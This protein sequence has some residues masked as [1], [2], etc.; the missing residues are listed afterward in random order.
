MTAAR[1]TVAAV[2]IGA[3]SG[4]VCT[5]DFDG[6]SLTL[7]V[8]HRFEHSPLTR[9]GG[10]HWDLD[11]IDTEVTAGLA[12]LSRSD[13]SIASVGVDTWGVDYGL[14]D[15]DG[16][17]V[18]LP[19]CHRDPSRVAAMHRAIESVGAESM[20]DSTGIQITPI[21]TVF[22]LLSDLH[23]HPDRIANAATMLMLP[24]VFHH[25]LSGSTVTEF[26]A[27]S[28]SGAYDMSGRR[29]AVD[30]L[31]RLGIP[32]RLL[33]EVV[34][35]GT[36]VGP[37]RDGTGALAG[38]RVILPP[39]HD[40]AS[41]VVAVPF[42]EPHALFISSGTWSLVGVEVDHA[43]TTAAAR[44]ANLSN[45]GGYDSTIRLLRNVMGLWLLQ[46]CRKQWAIEG[47]E[48]TYQ[49]IADAAEAEP[50][51]TSLI[52]PDSTV[53]L[54][55]GDM[56]ARIRAYC[57][58]TGGPVPHSIGEIARC[59]ADSLALSYAA[60]ADDIADVT[61]V[62]PPAV[63]VVGGGAS[64]RL[65]AQLTADAVGVPVLTGPVEATALGNAAAQLV[66]LG[67]LAGLPQIRDVVRATTDVERYEPRPRQ[68]WA[69]AHARFKN[70][71]RLATTR[72]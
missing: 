59:V 70:L 16:G 9:N 30:L 20:Y 7:E 42:T 4:R 52:D 5:V 53:F 1:R 51:L 34:A 49:E 63:H 39:G 68:E 64:H 14:L 67:E 8:G 44:Q 15:R 22:G 28:T 10:L 56:P 31:D 35:P 71:P 6:R 24:D 66:A 57:A 26:T 69:D 43:I 72:S 40:T 13:R 50:G 37:L 41:A 55:P 18:D 58:E 2:D 25:R 3:E 29:W 27:A 46:E 45:E 12:R 47:T 62:R 23:E 11:R 61:G 33:P 32:V 21:N 65:L 38:T 48:L 19:G 17:L 54:A 60:V 36:D